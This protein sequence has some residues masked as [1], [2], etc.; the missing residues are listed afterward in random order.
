MFIFVGK[1][2]PT[3]TQ[4]LTAGGCT[5]KDFFEISIA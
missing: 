3:F 4:Y 5:I 1:N 2:K